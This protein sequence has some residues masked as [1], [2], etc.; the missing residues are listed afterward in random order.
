MNIPSI[1]QQGAWVE[2]PD[3]TI[4][5]ERFKYE[6]TEPWEIFH[7]H[8]YGPPVKLYRN[9][10]G[11]L[12]RDL[13]FIEIEGRS[14]IAHPGFLWDGPSGPS[15]DSTSSIAASISHDGIYRAM[16]FGY[17][18]SRGFR[19]AADKDFRELCK[20]GGMS[21]FRRSYHWFGVRVG[22]R[23]SAKRFPGVPKHYEL[24]PSGRG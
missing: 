15:W 11:E 18:P 20:D 16:R 12:P 19:R 4:R 1:I 22:G 8:D 7:L 23:K 5:R 21:W 6:V 10:I 17:I 9:W 24:T 2:I 13:P 14:L 3:S